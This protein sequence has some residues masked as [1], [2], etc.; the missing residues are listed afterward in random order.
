MSQMFLEQVAN[1]IMTNSK[2]KQGPTVTQTPPSSEYCD[3]FTG[4]IHSHHLSQVFLEQSPSECSWNNLSQMFLE[5]VANFIM[6]NSKSK[7]GP[8]VTQTPP[9]SEY[10]DPF[11]GKIHSHHLSQVFLEQYES[12]VLGTG[13]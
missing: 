5:Q 2:S 4:K 13:G 1:F 11:T 8:T 10:C 3:P 6:T 9:S 7:Q 12:D